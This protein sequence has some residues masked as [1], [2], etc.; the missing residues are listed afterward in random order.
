MESAYSMKFSSK[1]KKQLLKIIF[2]EHLDISCSGIVQ[3][4]DGTFQ[5]VAYV[6]E[7]KKKQLLSRKSTSIDVI[8]L[9]D[10]LKTGIERQKE[11]SQRNRFKD[12]KRPIIKGLG[13]KE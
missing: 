4:A 10:M 13:I 9:E 2:G 11:V 12:T 1:D 6:N 7:E 5:V 3:S 8:V